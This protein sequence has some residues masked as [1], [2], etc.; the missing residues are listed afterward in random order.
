M[1]MS[2]NASAKFGTV[3]EKGKP[4]SKWLGNKTEIALLEWIT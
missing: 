3:M 4:V 1:A 2:C